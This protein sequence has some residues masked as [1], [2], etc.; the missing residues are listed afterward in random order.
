M[1]TVKNLLSIRFGRLVV[2]ADAGPG[3][4]GWLWLCKCDCGTAKTIRSAS[5]LCGRTRSCG[6]L[7]RE[8]ARS[9]G[10][11]T[12]T[13]GKS[14]QDI[15]SIWDSMIAR[16][17]RPSRKD[18]HRYGGS[19]I[20]VCDRWK[21][22][23]NFYNDMGDRPDGM[24]I[25]RID[26]TKGYHPDNCRWATAKTQARN[27]SKN[28]LITY[29]GR[30]QCLSAWAEEIGMS[31]ISLQSRLDR[32]WSVERSI[33]EPIDKRYAHDKN[34][35]HQRHVG[36]TQHLRYQPKPQPPVVLSRDA[37]AAMDETMTIQQGA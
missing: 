3:N 26:N 27:Q 16:C 25:D 32:G 22:F 15:Y 35:K 30:T 13:H 4:R 7:Q 11:R 24:S 14:K 1:S 20:S 23:Q 12:R 34:R 17:D 21:T 28:R 10:D 2:I 9:T 5:L 37:V 19:G 18:F 36:D 29:G 33:E 31:S 6:C 8:K